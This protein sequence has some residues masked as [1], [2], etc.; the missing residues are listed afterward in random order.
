MV[1]GLPKCDDHLADFLAHEY[2][3]SLEENWFRLG[4]VVCVSC[5]L[6]VN[7]I[8]TS[9]GSHRYEHFGSIVQQLGSRQILRLLFGSSHSAS[10]SCHN[11]IIRVSV[12]S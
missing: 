9:K 12:H 6:K 11:L 7:K 5:F 4:I 1:S 2:K 3:T 8:L 10:Y